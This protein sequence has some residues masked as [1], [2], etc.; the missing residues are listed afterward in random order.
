MNIPKLAINNYQLTITAFVALLALGLSAFFSMPQSEDPALEVPATMVVSIY[1]GASPEDVESQVVDPIEEVLNELE[2]VKEISTNIRDGVA[3]TEVEFY[4][5]VDPEEKFEEV[6]TQ[7]NGIKNELPQNLYDI[8]FIKQSTSTVAI[9]Q[10]ALVSNLASYGQMEAEAERV[11]KI[12]EKVSGVKKVE[13]EAFPEQEVRVALNPTKMSAMNISLE[14]IERAIQSNNAAIPGGALKVSNKLFNVKTSGAYEQIEEIKNTVVGSY[15]GKII[16]LKNVASVFFDYE[17]EK[18]TARFNGDRSVIITVQQKDGFNIFDV[19]DP[20]KAKLS[21]VKLAGDMELK[22]VFDQSIS[23]K[24]R[25]SGFVNNLLQGI[26]LVGLIILLLL[27]FRAS[28]IVMIAIPFSI[29][30]G[31]FFVD[32]FDL[33]LQ[34]MSITGLVVALGLLVDNSIAII[35]NIN[36]FLGEGMSA[37]DA[38]IKGTSQLG[39]SD[40]QCYFNDY[41]SICPNHHDARHHWRIYKSVA[42]FSD[43]D[44][45]SLFGHC[46]HAYS[47]YSE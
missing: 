19:A 24:D 26:A 30:I 39:C 45:F 1:P 29:L 12:I 9:F 15:M 46:G 11:K 6:Q 4:F 7:V 35:E 47:F 37:K 41:F 8:D 25:V 14:D 28:S 38:A 3:I 21:E 20:V 42:G 43:R 22:Y 34:Q 5:G 31:L 10:L 40:D 44:P 27:G 32:V 33:G 18:Y 17:D 13:I 16:Y 23:V 36:R 2:D